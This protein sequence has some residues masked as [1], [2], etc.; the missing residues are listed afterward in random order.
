MQDVQEIREGDMF[1][2]QDVKGSEKQNNKLKLGCRH[3]LK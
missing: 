2:T 3:W 1:G